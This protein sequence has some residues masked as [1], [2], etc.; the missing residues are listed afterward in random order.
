M[1]RKREF[2]SAGNRIPWESKAEANER[3]Y[4]QPWTE[5][6]VKALK[7]GNGFLVL[8]DS[9]SSSE[10]DRR[11][12]DD[13][14][15]H[16]AVMQSQINN[17]LF[18]GKEIGALKDMVGYPPYTFSEVNSFYRG[19]VVS[20]VQSWAEDGMRTLVPDISI[21]P[22]NSEDERREAVLYGIGDRND[23]SSLELA[24]LEYFHPT[25]FA[26]CFSAPTV[27]EEGIIRDTRFFV[28]WELFEDE[29]AHALGVPQDS[30][31]FDA[32]L[33]QLEYQC[34]SALGPAKKLCAEGPSVVKGRRRW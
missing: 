30:P 9:A 17:L 10:S 21:Y 19:A 20:L 22:P 6:V 8:V 24:F 26:K 1:F 28:Q 23:L 12:L 7:Q 4:T 3:Q 31:E 29:A 5:A 25:R 13:Q 27:E 33:D 11:Y 15:A 18:S 34:K 32:I 14:L 16:I 2:S